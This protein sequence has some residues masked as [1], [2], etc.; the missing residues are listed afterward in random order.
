LTHS[1][2]LQSGKKRLHPFHFKPFQSG[3]NRLP[4]LQ[5][6]PVRLKPTSSIPSHSG[7]A[8]TDFL[9]FKPV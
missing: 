4:L 9:L 8:K 1:K 5:A 7:L 3:Q 2:P 6:I